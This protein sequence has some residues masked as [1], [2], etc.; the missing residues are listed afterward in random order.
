MA[1]EKIIVI[2]YDDKP[3]V[4]V[5]VKYTDGYCFSTGIY[6]ECGKIIKA[7]AE[8]FGIDIKS[9]KLING[10]DNNNRAF[11]GFDEPLINTLIEQIPNSYG[12]QND[13]DIIGF[14]ILGAE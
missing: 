1:K 5:N 7:G 8:Y 10:H 4:K 3:P 6:N 13:V 14:S 2:K 11:E 12:L 9:I